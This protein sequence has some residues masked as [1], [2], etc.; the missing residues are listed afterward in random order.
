MTATTTTATTA[1]KA[2]D[3]LARRRIE[4]EMKR[5]QQE[6]K[7]N[8]QQAMRALIGDEAQDVKARKQGVGQS[9]KRWMGKGSSAEKHTSS[10]STT[11]QQPPVTVA[12]GNLDVV[13]ARK[14]AYAQSLKDNADKG[15]TY[16]NDDDDDERN[17][18]NKTP[19]GAGNKETK[20]RFEKPSFGVPSLFGSKRGTTSKP[21]QTNPNETPDSKSKSEQPDD[22]RSEFASIEKEEETMVGKEKH[23]KITGINHQGR[24][25]TKIKIILPK[26]RAETVPQHQTKGTAGATTTTTTTTTPPA[27]TTNNGAIIY[28]SLVD[29]RKG[30][31]KSKGF[32]KSRKEEYLAPGDFQEVFGMT[33]EDFAALSKWK[34]DKLKRKLGLF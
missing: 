14:L 13:N 22:Y 33:K 5:I 11:T 12:G 30:T 27:N 18:I 25:V 15:K 29:I 3:E 21:P 2:E 6:T 19:S 20:K 34:R 4:E 32:D 7:E 31:I 24:K 9:I 16:F 10:S 8:R 17:E 26:V 23:I 28:Y 1:T